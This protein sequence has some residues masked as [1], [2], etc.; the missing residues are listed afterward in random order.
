MGL[1]K[2]Q[3]NDSGRQTTLFSEGQLL[4]NKTIS[5]RS[6]MSSIIRLKSNSLTSCRVFIISPWSE[7][8]GL[9]DQQL[10][11]KMK[12]CWKNTRSNAKRLTTSIVNSLETRLR[13]GWLSF[14]FEVF[15]G[16]T[17][18]LVVHTNQRQFRSEKIYTPS[19]AFISN[20]QQSITNISTLFF[21]YLF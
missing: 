1:F 14:L 5:F 21:V 18:K 9:K 3:C 10:P 16:P 20:L 15:L 6:E 4:L 2:Q 11:Q 7:R 17:N 13:L 8:D 19:N 12:Y